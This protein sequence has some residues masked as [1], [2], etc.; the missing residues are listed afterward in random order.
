MTQ[1]LHQIEVK[2]E[3]KRKLE[4]N[5]QIKRDKIYSSIAIYE[6]LGSRFKQIVK[7]CI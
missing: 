6:P 4:G 3:E 2:G 7:K 1:F 5:L